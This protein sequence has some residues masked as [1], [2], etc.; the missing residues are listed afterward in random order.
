MTRIPPLPPLVT[1][2]EILTDSLP[3]LQPSSRMSVTDAAERHI[4]VQTGGVWQRFDRNVTPYMVEPADI[5]QSRRFRSVVFV[6]PSQSGKTFM[7]ITTA[8]HA[9]MCDPAPVQVIHMTKTDA[10]AWVEESLNPTIHN[11]P[12][13]YDR[14]G[15]GATDDSMGRKRFQGMR[16]TIGYPVPQQLSSR[17]QKIVLLTDYDHMPQQLGPKDNPEGTPHGMSL[18][19]IKTFLSRGTV[20]AESTPAFEVTDPEWAPMQSA[21]H[22]MP[23]VSA[24]IVPL[25]NGG[26]RGRWMWRCRDCD[27]MFEPRFDRLVYDKTR[28]PMDAGETAEMACP[29][30]GGLTP[31]RMKFELNRTALS[32]HGGWLHEA[33]DGSLV[34]IGDSNLRGTDTASYALNGAAATFANWANLVATYETARR[35]FEEDGDELGLRQFHFV[36]CGV[37]HVPMNGAEG[38]GVSLEDLK[39][40]RHDLPRGTAPEWTRFITTTVDVQGTYFPVLVTAWGLDGRRTVI[41]RIDLTQPSDGSQ[42]TLDPAKFA[43]DWDVLCPLAMQVYPVA[44]QSYG[45]RSVGVVVDFHG[46]PGVSDNAEKFWRGRRAAGEGQL[47]FLSRGHGGFHQRDRVWHEAPE[48]ASQGKRKRGVKLLNMATDRLKD[49]IA[50][51]LDRPESAASAFPLPEWMSDD[52]LRE[53][54]AELRT[55]KGWRPKPGQRRNENTDLSVQAQALAE[56]KGLRRINPEN[57]PSWAHGGPQNEFAVADHQASTAQPVE[58]RTPAPAAPQRINFLKR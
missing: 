8:L 56:H 6:G 30:C 19:R 50:A 28:D 47:W 33:R 54:I 25:Y 39:R 5:T 36:D 22:M 3:L 20:V 40:D 2:E 58:A 12:D 27:E 45:L 23:P 41:D 42:R 37:P 9:V 24:G 14:L 38:E 48:R 43:A 1:V 7:L 49:T 34:E 10:N 16:L 44:G 17:K 32:G 13:V 4:R 35:R 15:R 31:H 46:A 21:P 29:H 55:E 52:H 11:S 53:F 51:A 57:P 18:Q 26:T